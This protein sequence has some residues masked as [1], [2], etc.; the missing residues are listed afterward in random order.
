MKEESDSLN[1]G[2]IKGCSAHIDAAT[3]QRIKQYRIRHLK[4]HPGQPLPG[5]PQIIRHA[6]N[7]WLDG[8]E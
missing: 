3:M 1:L 4:E 6:V 7:Q 5:V 2:E 8:A